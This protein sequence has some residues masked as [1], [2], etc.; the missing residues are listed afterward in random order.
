MNLLFSVNMRHCSYIQRENFPF[1]EDYKCSRSRTTFYYTLGY[2]IFMEDSPI[3]FRSSMDP[4]LQVILFCLF[5]LCIL[6][7]INSISLAC[8]IGHW[9]STFIL[10][11]SIHSYVE[12]MIHKWFVVLCFR[13]F[14]DILH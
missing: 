1:L 4:L 3:K 12:I 8:G 14:G 11:L 6:I 9:R 7:L 10:V 5:F 2:L 13:L